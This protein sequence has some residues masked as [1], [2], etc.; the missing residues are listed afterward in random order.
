MPTLL[1]VNNYHY[2]RGGADVVYLEQS[3]LLREQGWHVADFAMQHPR[4]EASD[5]GEYFAEEIEFG[6]GYGALTKAKHAAK[7]IYSFESAAKIRRLIEKVK[8]DVVHAHNV[9]HH[10]SPSVL[11]AAHDCGV[12][13]VLT[14]HDLKLLCPAYS[15]LSHGRVCEDCNTR[16]RKALLEK[17][18]LKGSLALS[19]LIYLES[20]LHDAL[21]LYRKHVDRLISPSRFLADKFGEWGWDGA[22]LAHVPN[23]ADV[24]ALPPQYRPGRH[25]LYFG[26]LSREKGLLTLIDAVASAGV[27][28]WLVGTGP[29]EAELRQR[30][31]QT[32]A[33]VRF[34]GFQQGDAL[35]Q[36]V[37]DCRAIV[38]ASE[39]YENAPLTILEAYA[40]G[41]PAIG[42]AIGGI[43]ELI[44]PGETGAV[45][46]S[47]NSE[48]LARVLRDYAAMA[49]A[50]I[51]EQ[52]GRA[53]AW[54]EQDFT[55]ERHVA[56]LQ[57]VYREV[58]VRV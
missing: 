55:V 30:A 4:N 42:A 14:A 35:W 39:C 48:D 9:Y 54:V 27:E 22:P 47:G 40:C 15:M 53:R 10:L 52:G 17:R 19:G 57:Q 56:R 46:D 38:L 29:L 44:R 11:K 3:R 24:G 1:A 58:G 45:F 6:H 37:R 8:P 12:P 32:G 20:S 13:V 43:P 41:K 36:L 26:R 16:G 31:E 33:N 51:A 23:F 50:D 18:C 7:I 34:C 21:G 2:R 28:L 49:D 25:F 5:Y